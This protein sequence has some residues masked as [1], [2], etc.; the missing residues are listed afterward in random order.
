VTDAE[1][2]FSIQALPV[3]NYQVETT[4][5]AYKDQPVPAWIRE[6][7]VTELAIRLEPGDPFLDLNV[8]QHAWL[9]GEA[10]RV[11]VHG[12]R[13]GDDLRLRLM[14]VDG[15]TLLRD[16]GARVRQMLTPVST[17]ARPGTFAALKD[18]AF[19]PLREWS[20]HVRKKDAEGVFYDWLPLG[21]LP[22]GVY[23]VQAAGSAS[24]ALGWLMVTDLALV[25]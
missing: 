3:G 25:T 24:E 14:E 7:Q 6:G 12:F 11:A 1:G 15:L 5:T 18:H 10:P 2:R 20:Y 19:R 8:H 9:P 23:L 16:H 13:Q 4:T 21:P 22:E 17:T